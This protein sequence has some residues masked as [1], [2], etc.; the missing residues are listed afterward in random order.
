[1]EKKEPRTAILYARVKPANRKWIKI[2]A[3]RLGYKSESE[4]MDKVL[5]ELRAKQSDRKSK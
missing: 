5:E 3:K 4:F 2:E 1:M